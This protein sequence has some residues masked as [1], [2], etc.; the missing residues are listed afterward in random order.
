[1]GS[2]R[3]KQVKSVALSLKL[4]RDDWSEPKSISMQGERSADGGWNTWFPRDQNSGALQ[5]RETL[6][7]KLASIEE[8]VREYIVENALDADWETLEASINE[9]LK[10]GLTVEDLEYRSEL[11]IYAI[12]GYGYEAHFY[13]PMMATAFSIE[14]TE[15]LTKNDLNHA[16]YCVDRGLYWSGPGIFLP[17]PNDRFTERARTGG[18][19]KDFRRE[20]VKDKVAELLIKLVPEEGWASTCAAIVAVETE[21]TRKYSSLV[22]ECQLKTDNLPRTIDTWIQVDPERFPHRIMSKI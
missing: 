15:A 10:S 18:L 20:P 4:Y 19:G 2:P 17:N 13:A 22:A 12:A 16:S 11:P 8:H 1:M 3:D 5:S 21:L 9:A 14:G 7:G 6:K